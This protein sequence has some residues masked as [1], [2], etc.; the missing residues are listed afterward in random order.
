MG[1][2]DLFSSKKK[3]NVQGSTTQ[4]SAGSFD[5]S[6][7]SRMREERRAKGIH[8]L[9]E[10]RELQAQGNLDSAIEK[11]TEA[12][13]LS[14][15]EAVMALAEIYEK[16]GEAEKYFQLLS[17]KHTGAGYNSDYFPVFFA[18]AKCYQNGYGTARNR[19]KA[20]QLALDF[21]KK[22]EYSQDSIAFDCFLAECSRSLYLDSAKASQNSALK[23]SPFYADVVTSVLELTKW[24]FRSMDHYQA[25]ADK[26]DI[27][28]MVKTAEIT[29]NPET[30]YEYLMKASNAGHHAAAVRLFWRFIQAFEQHS[31]P[32]NFDMNAVVRRLEAG[33][34]A[35]HT[36][37]MFA[38]AMCYAKDFVG[39]YGIKY[40]LHP[41]K[42]PLA[43]DQEKL[44]FWLKQA[45]DAGSSHPALLLLLA[46]Y[47]ATGK[48]WKNKFFDQEPIYQGDRSCVDPERA[49]SLLLQAHEKLAEKRPSEKDGTTSW[50]DA[51]CYLLGMCYFDGCGTAANEDAACTILNAQRI[52]DGMEVDHETY[53]QL[54]AIR[55]ALKE[56]QPDNYDSFAKLLASLSEAETK[57]AEAQN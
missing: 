27:P 12:C 34:E 11:Y 20:Y 21:K 33:A 52:S 42:S 32:D 43:P 48:M 40:N 6:A 15:A 14:I 24:K 35:G 54:I 16:R 10:G 28:S 56:A 29:K 53:V 36:D 51:I 46:E 55:E 3:N 31:T 39:S 22:W 2:F 9:N 41:V 17:E 45:Y 1:L 7:L 50:S 47:Y 57:E 13:D 4:T 8:L 18:Y 23:D 44:L 5:P 49:F 30:V 19:Q 26:G 25:A 37:C 38:L